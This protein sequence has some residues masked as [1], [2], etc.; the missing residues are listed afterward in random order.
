MAVFDR[1]AGESIG[2]SSDLNHFIL[3]YLKSE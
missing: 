1:F 2:E 3:A